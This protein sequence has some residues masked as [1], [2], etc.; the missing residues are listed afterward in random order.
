MSEVF[1]LAREH[2]GELLAALKNRGYQV[3]GPRV[4]EG[5]IVYGQLDSLEDLPIGWTEEQEGGTYRL[6]KRRDNALFGYTVGPHSWK[7]LLHSP[8]VRLWQ[9]RKSGTSFQIIEE[10]REVPKMAFLGVRACELRAIAIQDA[11]FL[12]GKFVDQSYKANREGVS[13]AHQREFDQTQATRLRM[14][15]AVSISGSPADNILVIGIG[16]EYAQD[17]AAGL[18]VARK[19][20]EQVRDNIRVI[21]SGGEGASLMEAWKGAFSAIVIDGV[22]S[23]AEPGSIYRFDAHQKALPVQPFRGSTH[24]FGLYEAIELSRSLNQ[25]PQRLIVYG[26]EG[27]NF[28]AETNVSGA[29]TQAVTAVTRSI[30]EEIKVL[31]RLL[32]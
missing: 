23:G 22:R 7:Q 6:K 13:I 10:K 2:F 15:P 19:L 1:I 29:I 18:L 9:A 4:R 21:E 26:V 16:N 30:I 25:L 14:G 32:P 31:R 28:T 17:D 5:A 20:R 12:G 8:S 11:V 27:Q 24:A 3:I